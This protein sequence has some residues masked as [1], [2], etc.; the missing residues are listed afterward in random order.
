MARV[1]NFT[2]VG[3]SPFP[4]DMLRYDA[5]YPATQESVGEIEASRDSQERAARRAEGWKDKFEVDLR[6]H[7]GAPTSARW[8]SFGWR[9]LRQSI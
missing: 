7:V 9:I 8:S 2:V 3:T 5:C 1:W 4:N 6:S